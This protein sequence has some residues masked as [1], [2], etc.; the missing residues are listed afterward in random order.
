MFA[1]GLPNLQ[2]LRRYVD[3]HEFGMEWKEHVA[4]FAPMFATSAAVLVTYYGRRLAREP[5][6][7]RV[8]ILLFMLAF[9]TATVAGVLGALITK[10]APVK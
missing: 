1:E 2:R 5:R 9:G 7:R 6:V 8:A 3:W 10:V 4:W